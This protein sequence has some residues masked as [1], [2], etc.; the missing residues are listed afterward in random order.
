[1]DARVQDEIYKKQFSGV[2]SGGLQWENKTRE[3]KSIGLKRE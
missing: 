3:L 2:P 1:M